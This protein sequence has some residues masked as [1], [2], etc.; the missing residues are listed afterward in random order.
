MN[1][2]ES[3]N[4]HTLLPTEIKVGE[5]WM[6]ALQLEKINPDDNFFEQ[7]GDSLMT[8]MMLFRVSDVLNVD[9]PPDVLMEAPTLREFCKAIDGRQFVQYPAYTE[10]GVI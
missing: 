8:M 7:G 10:T 6:E 4:K 5:I 1:T 2:K 9:V 3:D